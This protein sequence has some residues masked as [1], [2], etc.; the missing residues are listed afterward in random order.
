[1]TRYFKGK[2]GNVVGGIAGILVSILAFYFVFA[3]S[4]AVAQY[5]A[6]RYVIIESASGRTVYDA[7]SLVIGSGGSTLYI[8]GVAVD[9]SGWD[10]ITV[11]LREKNKFSPR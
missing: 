10:E 2:L 5:T 8:Q 11:V 4:V 6:P 1:M 7:D 9:V 3:L